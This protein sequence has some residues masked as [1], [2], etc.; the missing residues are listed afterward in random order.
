[1]KRRAPKRI[2]ADRR[3]AAAWLALAPWLAVAAGAGVASAEDWPDWGRDGTRNMVSPETGLPV[4]LDAGTIDPATNVLDVSKAAHVKWVAKLGSQTYGN[5]TV[6]GGRVLVGTNNGAP[7]DPRFEGDYSMV[8]AFDE[9]TGAF[10]WQLATPKLGAG[11]VSDWEFLGICSSPAQH[12]GRAYVV[13]NRGDVLALDVRGQSNGNDRPYVAESTY[14]AA[15]KGPPVKVSR[16]ADGDILWRYAMRE[17]LGVFPHNITSSTALLHAG[18]LYVSTSN[19]VDW[20]HK[21][22]PAPYAP[23]LVV[24]DAKTGALVGEEAVGISR[25]VMHD[26]WSTPSVATLADGSHVGAGDGWLYGFDPVPKPGADG[27]PVLTERFRYDANPKRY[28]V[29]DE[30]TPRRYT[31]RQ[32]PSEIIATPVSADG[33]V[34]V[35]IGQDPEHGTG[36]GA[37]SAVDPR[38]RGDITESGRVWR[39]EDIGRSLSTV[40]VAD[41]VVYAA[42]LAG[43]VYA[44]DA[45]KGDLL[46]EH[47]TRGHI[48]G[49]PLVADGKVYLGNED[50]VMTVFAAGREAK[51]LHQAQFHSAIYGSAIAANK[52]LFIATHE[53]LYALSSDAKGGKVR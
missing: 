9:G 7:R 32:G 43:H 48:W 41:G 34:Y 42:D 1:M 10:Q 17:E 11:K 13:T 37:L 3:V 35:S 4:A 53:H 12:G 28:R 22:I 36:V 21:N 29:D 45:R 39:F 51:V 8:M 5:P 19:G 46:W 6:A 52:T 23:A 30:G 33:L 15:E 44:L 18:R 25:R 26:N 49:S 40:A 20:S 14:M 27:V 31:R 16:K 47:D 50:G 24:L 38:L 2:L